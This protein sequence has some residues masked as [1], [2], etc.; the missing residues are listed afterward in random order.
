M[1]IVKSNSE[2]VY[3]ISESNVTA[4]ICQHLKIKKSQK[5]II[6]HEWAFSDPDFIK[7]GGKAVE[8]IIC[9]GTFYANSKNEKLLTFKENYF[10]R[11]GEKITG[12]ARLSYEATQILF[13]ALSKT[14]NPKKL[15]NTIL[16]QKTFEGLDG[17]I[18]L[19]NFGD[20]VR[21]LYIME[22]QNGNYNNIGEIEIEDLL[23][24]EN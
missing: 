7:N 6:V 23:T 16:K 24:N 13:Y 11:F 14:T 20:P 15:K 21:K 18:I 4:L 19:D 10:K 3:I 8:K 2:A 22:I 17:E 5:K 12:G 1:Q 9:I